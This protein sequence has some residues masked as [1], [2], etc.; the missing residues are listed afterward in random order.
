[1]SFLDQLGKKL[2]DAGQEAAQQ[3]RNLTGRA[4]LSN[5]IYEREKQ[6]RTWYAE[7]GRA[8]YLAHARDPASLCR[9][10]MEAITAAIAANEADQ[11]RLDELRGAGKC[12]ACG[13]AVPEGAKFCPSCGAVLPPDEAG[14]PWEP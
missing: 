5:A 10:Q 1:M 8:Y 12:P 11:A 4:K 2:S 13:G 3:T 14:R 6:I 9:E 7:I